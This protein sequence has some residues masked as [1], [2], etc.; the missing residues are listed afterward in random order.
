MNS[1]PAPEE[2]ELNKKLALRDRLADRLASFEEEMANLRTELERFEVRY[3][4]EVGRLYAEQ[5]EIDAQIAEEEAKLVPDDVEIQNRAEELRRRA[6]ESA[7]RAAAAEIV[8]RPA[9]TTEAK[10]AYHN[11]A[12]V[13]HPDLATEAAEKK[14]RH[15]M[16]ARLNAA[17]SAGDQTMLD[18]LAEEL[19]I[20]PDVVT[21]SSMGDDLVRVI[22]QISQIKRRFRELKE[23]RNASEASE[24]FLLLMKVR[25]EMDEGRDL[26]RQMA[27]RARSYIKKSQRRLENLRNVNAAAEEYVKDKYG[28]DIAD[29]RKV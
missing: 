6:E 25:D 21:G 20:S 15:V 17:Y 11:L 5:D 13:I 14:K 8:E 19:R 1:S 3:V 2:I 22:R 24:L 18:K 29:F 28:M 10:K 12:R 16:M 23:E 26:L 27:E 4:I 7:A 9:P